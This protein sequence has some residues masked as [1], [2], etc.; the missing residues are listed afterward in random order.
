[1]PTHVFDAGEQLLSGKKEL[2]RLNVSCKRGRFP[3]NEY[4]ST[5]ISRELRSWGWLDH[6]PSIVSS[7]GPG[8]VVI[9]YTAVFSN[10]DPGTVIRRYRH[11]VGLSPFV[12]K[13]ENDNRNFLLVH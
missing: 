2:K 3:K 6:L 9:Q 7:S 5:Y 10:S 4:K 12:S 1:M 13:M 8:K 11:D